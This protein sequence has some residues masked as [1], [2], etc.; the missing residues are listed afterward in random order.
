MSSSTLTLD[1]TSDV[2]IFRDG[3]R[4]AIE[5]YQSVGGSLG[6]CTYLL[7]EVEEALA[8]ADDAL[9][10]GVFDS[11]NGLRFFPND[12]Q[13]MYVQVQNQ[14]RRLQV[15]LDPMPEDTGGDTEPPV[16]DEEPSTTDDPP[17]APAEGFPWRTVAGLGL[18]GLAAWGFWRMRR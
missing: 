14:I 12:P 4:I 18:L 17:S 11:T 15:C 7:N 1:Q 8:A 2:V 6:D 16:E 10:A 13:A 3:L 5:A 9:S